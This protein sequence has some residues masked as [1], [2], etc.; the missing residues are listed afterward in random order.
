MFKGRG[1]DRLHQIVGKE[2]D[3]IYRKYA[4]HVFFLSV[5]VI[6]LKAHSPLPTHL[7]FVF[8]YLLCVFSIYAIML[9]PHNLMQPITSSSFKHFLHEAARIPMLPGFP[10][11]DL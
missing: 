6:N 3:G 10:Y 4:E 7:L 1:S 2:H 8:I 5:L 11:P 9:F